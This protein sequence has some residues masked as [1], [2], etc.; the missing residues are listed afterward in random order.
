VKCFF[1]VQSQI[2]AMMDELRDLK[3][4]AILGELTEPLAGIRLQF[5]EAPVDPPP[6]PPHETTGGRLRSVSAGDVLVTSAE[7]T[8]AVSPP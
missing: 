2:D 8:R 3:S 1:T 4:I 5:G 7:Y 6:V